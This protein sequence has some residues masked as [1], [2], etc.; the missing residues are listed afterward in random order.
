LF[1]QLEIWRIQMK[2]HALVALLLCV[3]PVSAMAQAEKTDPGSLSGKAQADRP[4]DAGG[5]AQPNAKA[6]D[7]TKSLPGKA[8]EDHPGTDA[9]GTTANPTADP[10]SG[11][12]PDKAKETTK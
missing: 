7:D 12:L 6:D 1:E 5:T 4:K 2:T 10:K 9:T 3:L 8:A 11:S